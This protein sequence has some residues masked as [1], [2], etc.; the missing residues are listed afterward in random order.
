MDSDV[1]ANKEKRMRAVVTCK[2]KW[3]AALV[4][5]TEF[6]GRTKKQNIATTVHW[7]LEKK[8]GE[9]QQSFLN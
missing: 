6:T 2:R 7:E 1:N 8:K 3:E 5:P 9:V 4:V